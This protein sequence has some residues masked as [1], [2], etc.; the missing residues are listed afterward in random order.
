MIF[1][2]RRVSEAT[3]KAERKPSYLARKQKASEK[4]LF[5]IGVL[6]RNVT[7]YPNRIP[8]RQ[9]GK[10]VSLVIPDPKEALTN[11]SDLIYPLIRGEFGPIV[12]FWTDKIH[13]DT[14]RIGVGF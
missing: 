7:G 14:K 9:R 1:D 4:T 12:S 8:H 10:Y 3:V 11:I 2:F 5:M 13:N 6:K